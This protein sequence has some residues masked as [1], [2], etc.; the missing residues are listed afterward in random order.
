V[1]ALESRS[2]RPNHAKADVV[3]D[4]GHP[5]ALGG[6]E[7]LWIVV[8]GTAA[9]NAATETTFECPRCAISRRTAVIVVMIGV[10]HRFRFPSA[11][12]PINRRTATRMASARVHSFVAAHSSSN[13]NS[14][15]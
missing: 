3:V 13:V 10:C 2:K 15:G 4:E 5:L 1:T 9:D 7:V 6:A 8:P 12:R 14:G 11:S